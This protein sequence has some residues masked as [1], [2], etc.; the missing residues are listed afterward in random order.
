MSK[1]DLFT[2]ICVTIEVTEPKEV[3]ITKFKDHFNMEL[4]LDRLNLPSYPLEFTV[5]FPLK[6][7]DFN[8]HMPVANGMMYK[9]DNAKYF[10]TLR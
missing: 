7:V 5:K 3:N 9:S 8:Q 2:G 4:S 6:T 10:I 1:I